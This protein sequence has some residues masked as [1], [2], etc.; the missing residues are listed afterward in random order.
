MYYL[1][2]TKT[3][4]LN[5]F[6]YI[7]E[8]VFIPHVISTINVHT[9]MYVSVTLAKKFQHQGHGVQTWT[10]VTTTMKYALLGSQ[11]PDARSL[12]DYQCLRKVRLYAISQIYVTFME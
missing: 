10:C 9:L 1:S 4:H 12:Q 3:A 8:A 2:L 11:M 7:Q 5:R 6:L